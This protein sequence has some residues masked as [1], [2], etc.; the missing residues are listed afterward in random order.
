MLDTS[1]QVKTNQ[2]DGP[3]S[4]LLLLIQKEQMNIRELDLKLIT[5]QYLEYLDYMQE[6]NFDVAGDY[7]YLAATLIYLKSKNCITEDDQNA[8]Q[9][10]AGEN[11]ALD[12]F[13]HADLIK[14]LEELQR[15]QKL[16]EQ[17]WNLP[18]RGRDV[19]VRPKLNKKYHLT[20]FLKKVE[21]DELTLTM[22]DYL[23]REQR[24]YKVVKRDRLSIK[25]KLRYLKEN[26]Q[27][28]EQTTLNE[29]IRGQED[30]SI[31]NLVINFISL[32][33]LARLKRIEI[34]QN[35]DR[36]EVYLNVKKSLDDF[37]IEQADG[38][39]PEDEVKEKKAAE[40]ESVKEESTTEHTDNIETNVETDV[41]P[42]VANTNMEHEPPTQTLQ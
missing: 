19:F 35:D 1:I 17:L 16:G 34:F 10:L 8:L 24:K 11:D 25:E 22:V 6:L 12:I 4:L 36:G 23:F 28:G 31:T 7:L 14:R 21:L 42:N 2:F 20:T 32:L 38:F 26:L 15:F 33:E 9:E 29:I 40:A 30:G 27:L 39:D 37:D 3:L 5:K 41:V 13:S 18:Q